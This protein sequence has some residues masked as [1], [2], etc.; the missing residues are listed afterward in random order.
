[1]DRS[2]IERNRRQTLRL[3]A[4]TAC[5]D[6][7][8]AQP[9]GEHWTV[10]VAL[11]HLGYWDL[12]GVGALEAW[13][14]HGLPLV[15]WRGPEGVNDARLPVWRAMAPREALDQAIRI[16]EA[17]DALIA[18]LSDAEAAVVAAQYERMLERGRHRGEHLA[19]IEHALR[20]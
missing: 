10:G 2:Y 18:S 16:A 4:L 13:R 20:L 15:F 19:E 17:L 11:A 12:R 1:M 5:S 14:R 6:E 3:Q 8:P 9:L 7:Q